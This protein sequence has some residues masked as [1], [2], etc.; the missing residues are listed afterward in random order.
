MPRFLEVEQIICSKRAF[1][2]QTVAYRNETDGME[3]KT[4]DS[5]EVSH[6]KSLTKHETNHIGECL[7]LNRKEANR[8]ILD[9]EDNLV[10]TAENLKNEMAEKSFRDLVAT[11]NH[12]YR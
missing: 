12:S 4:S 10:V 2:K 6:E 7:S 1:E 5:T 9:H 8:Y 3:S 11:N